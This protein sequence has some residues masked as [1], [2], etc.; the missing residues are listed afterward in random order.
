MPEL[1]LGRRSRSRRLPRGTKSGSALSVGRAGVQRALISNNSN[2]RS[3][4]AATNEILWIDKQ[5]VERQR[6]DFFPPVSGT[7]CRSGELFL[8]VRRTGRC[9]HFLCR[10]GRVVQYL[11]C[12]PSGRLPMACR[13]VGVEIIAVARTERPCRAYAS[14]NRTPPLHK[15]KHHRFIR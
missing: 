4:Y 6:I 13:S 14:T 7:T 5:P 2:F 12:S 1:R 8:L 9:S 11:Y 10:S 3:I 15:D